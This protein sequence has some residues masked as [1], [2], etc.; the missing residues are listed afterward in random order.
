MENT[1]KLEFATVEGN[2]VVRTLTVQGAGSMEHAVEIGHG[3]VGALSIDASLALYL[4]SVH[5][6]TKNFVL[7]PAPLAMRS[8]VTIS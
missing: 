8:G 1:Y 3:F 7:L 5:G 2:R 4:S 6:D